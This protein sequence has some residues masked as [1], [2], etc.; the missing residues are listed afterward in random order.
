MRKT[1]K[2]LSASERR[3]VTVQAVITLASEQNPG[4]ITTADIAERMKVT[5]GALFRHFPSKEA[6][7]QAVMSWVA[8]QLMARVDKVIR[9]ESAPMVALEGIFMAHIKFVVDHPGVPRMLFGEL[10]H[11]KDTPAKKTARGLIQEYGERI[12]TLLEQAKLNKEVDQQLDTAA[13]ATLFVGTIQGLVMQS[14]LVGD[15]T[16]MQNEAGRVF[17]I[18]QRGIGR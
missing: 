11:A 5:Q 2:N 1:R 8:E 10:Q 4:S 17:R 18:F 6:I 7:W 9:D 14:L 15:I 16:A 13:A 12:V 3:E